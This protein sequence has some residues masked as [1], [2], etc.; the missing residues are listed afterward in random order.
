MTIKDKYKLSF[1]KTNENGKIFFICN[2]LGNIDC[3]RIAN[4]INQMHIIECE[5]LLNEIIETQKGNYFEEYFALDNDE[6]SD[7][8]QLRISPPNIIINLATKIPL[9]DMKNLLMEW[10]DF[11]KNSK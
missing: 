11:V 9:E 10:I 8:D 4:K 2:N 5:G 1:A 3:Q 7:E 6:A